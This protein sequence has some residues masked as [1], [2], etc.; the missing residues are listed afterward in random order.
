MYR[1][2]RSTVVDI[3]LR[4]DRE[5]A[6]DMGL[7]GRFRRPEEIGAA[8]VYLASIDGGTIRSVN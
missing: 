8:V 6:V 2:T 1:Q 5:D 7:T 3:A 4:L